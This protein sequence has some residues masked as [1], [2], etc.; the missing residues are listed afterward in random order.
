MG[1]KL[2]PN[3]ANLFM[4]DLESKSIFNYPKQPILY[5]RYIDDIFFI[6]THGTT[7]LD[8]FISHLNSVHPTIKFASTTSNTSITYL[9]QDIYIHNNQFQT[10]THFKTTNTFSYLHGK[11]NHPFTFPGILKGEN[12]RILRNTSDE[13]TYNSTMTFLLQQCNH[14]AYPS[15]LTS[16]PYISFNQRP[17]YLLP[18]KKEKNQSCNFITTFNPSL[19]L[20]QTILEDWP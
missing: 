18:S 2:V 17:Q 13:K 9:D 5:R 15:H 6:W 12:I 11:S 20:K 10:K 19:S 8:N 4:A 1:T 3:Y 14:H 16:I 7:K